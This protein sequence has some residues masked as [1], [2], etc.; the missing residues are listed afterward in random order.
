MVANQNCTS[1]K[2]INCLYEFLEIYPSVVL[3]ALCSDLS[4]VLC[5]ASLCTYFVYSIVTAKASFIFFELACYEPVLFEL[6]ILEPATSELYN[7]QTCYSGTLKF[8]GFNA[9][10]KTRW[11]VKWRVKTCKYLNKIFDLS[12]MYLLIRG[13][14]FLTTF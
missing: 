11:F 8:T 14:D 13:A 12:I 4:R 9:L 1:G 7:F 2:F 6:Y 5:K 3:C 10:Y